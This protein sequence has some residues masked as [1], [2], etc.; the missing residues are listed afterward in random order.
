[1]PVGQ[2]MEPPRKPVEGLTAAKELEISD[3]LLLGEPLLVLAIQMLLR[4]STAREKGNAIPAAVAWALEV[5]E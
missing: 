1:M 3:T 4:P 2:L 5:T